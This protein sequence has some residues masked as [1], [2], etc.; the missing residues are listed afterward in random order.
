M[1]SWSASP[2][3]ATP[4]T[5]AAAGF[6][7]QTVRDIIFSSVGG[8]PIRLELT[9]VFGASPL[10]VGHV[11]VA[12]AGPGAAVAPGTIHP[13]TYRTAARRSSSGRRAG[14]QR[15]GGHVG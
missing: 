3:V 5:L 12:V 9:N 14:P 2:Q 8:D 7:N 15:S 4:G 1:T 13:V 6:D 11:T 10:R